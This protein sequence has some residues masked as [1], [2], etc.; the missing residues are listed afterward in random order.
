MLKCDLGG[1]YTSN[2]FRELL[3]SH[4]II[5]HMSCTDTLKQNDVF[6]RKYR[7]IVE[8]ARFLLLLMFIP[9][10]FLGE[11]VLIA[12]HLINKIPSSHTFCLSSFETLYKTKWCC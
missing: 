6:E 1:E 4:G 11:V 8:I 5:H 2:A 3:V 7:H 10:E 12:I 9:I